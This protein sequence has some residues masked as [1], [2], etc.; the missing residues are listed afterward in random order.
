MNSP[1]ITKTMYKLPSRDNHYCFGCSPV[2]EHGLQ[3]QFYTDEEMVYSDVIIPGHL[4]GWNSLAHGGVL[5][6]ILDEIMSWSAIFLL[7]R[8]IMTKSMTVDF[9]KP[10]KVGDKLHVKGSLIERI[11]EREALM[12]GQIFNE[13]GELCAQSK[14]TFALFTIESIKKMNIMDRDD[15]EALEALFSKAE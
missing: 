14:G 6:T 4:C 12:E 13:K 7:K 10:I 9:K 5:S 15:V 11:N 3:M 1:K 2:N 8:V